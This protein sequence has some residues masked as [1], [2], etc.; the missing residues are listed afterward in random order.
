M[1]PGQIRFFIC[2]LLF[3]HL[4]GALKKKHVESQERLGRTDPEQNPGERTS[5][6]NH[7]ETDA[8]CSPA[9]LS[10]GGRALDE[11]P[12]T[13]REMGFRGTEPA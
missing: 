13:A 3:F 8:A 11:E 1:A 6:T 5:G 7:L 4:P 10:R 12:G 2:N 9:T